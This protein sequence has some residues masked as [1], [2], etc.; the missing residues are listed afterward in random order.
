MAT[1]ASQSLFLR[2]LACRGRGRRL[3]APAA[4]ATGRCRAHTRSPE[5]RPGGL[6]AGWLWHRP[7]VG[8]LGPLIEV[9]T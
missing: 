7:E 5:K 8:M 1:L 6:A 2:V 9:L 3:A 4:G